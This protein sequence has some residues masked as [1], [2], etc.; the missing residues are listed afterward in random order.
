MLVVLGDAEERVSAAVVMALVALS[1][2]ASV[3]LGVVL[4]RRVGSAIWLRIVAAAIV[5]GALLL[6]WLALS[7]Y[8]GNCAG[9]DYGVED[10]YPADWRITRALYIIAWP[11]ACLTASALGFFTHISVPRIWMATLVGSA[12]TLVLLFALNAL[13]RPGLFEPCVPTPL[14]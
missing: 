12:I 2:V 11:S 9:R 1:L 6:L 3:W 13:L 14:T 10:Y 7:A 4:E 8:A 5:S